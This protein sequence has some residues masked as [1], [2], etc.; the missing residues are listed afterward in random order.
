MKVIKA[1]ILAG[2]LVHAICCAKSFSGD[3]IVE[4]GEA[5]IAKE[6]QI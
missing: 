1:I 6:A 4:I 2:G 3:D 5:I